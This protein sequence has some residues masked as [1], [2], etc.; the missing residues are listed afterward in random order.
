MK[1][2]EDSST[3]KVGTEKK[4]LGSLVI[5]V[6]EAGEGWQTS[7]E[8]KNLSSKEIM[9]IMQ[10]VNNNIMETMMKSTVDQM[11]KKRDDA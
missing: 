10:S 5:N 3:V 7:V 8:I 11:L 4:G 9:T 1:K 2:V 6:Q